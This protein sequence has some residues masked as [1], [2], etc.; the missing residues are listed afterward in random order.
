MKHPNEH[1]VVARNWRGESPEERRLQ[2]RERLMEASL[3]AFSQHGIE[4]TTMRDICAQARLTER[5][6]YESFRNTEDAFDAV[7]AML[8]QELVERVSTALARA[9]L[10]IP[11]LARD[12]LAAFYNFIKE[13][14]RRA[15]IM[16]IDA[17]YANRKTLDKSRDAVKEYVVII[18]Q[19]A[20]R[21]YPNMPANFDV[22]MVAWGLIGMCIQVGTMWAA[23]GFKQ[24]LDK[25]LD[26]N[27]YAWR[28]LESWI[29]APQPNGK[30][31]SLK[32][33]AKAAPSMRSRRKPSVA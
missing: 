28:G 6:F 1:P 11:Q 18:D 13:D 7:Y 19:L 29:D 8:K 23:S 21:L 31:G 26:Y 9:P 4:K 25:I 32:A 22:E 2:R 33:H 30:L 15:Q 17:F 20:R 24:P 27:L 5:Y 14:P 10:N 16:L 3:E 12:G